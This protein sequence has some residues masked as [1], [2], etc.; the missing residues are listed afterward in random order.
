MNIF[1]TS[2]QSV[3]ALIGIGLLGFWIIRKGIFPG[4]VLGLLSPLA[5]DIALPSLIFFNI[6]VNFSPVETEGWWQLPL[7]W[8]GFTVVTAFMTAIAV[9]TSQRITRREFALS[10]FYQ[11]ALFFPLIILTGLFG[12]SSP[13]MV[14]LFLFAFFYPAFLF[15]TYHFFFGTRGRGINLRKVLHPVLFATFFAVLIRYLGIQ[16]YVPY[17]VVSTFKILGGMSAPIIMI[18][19][20]GNI[21]LDF[22]RKGPFYTG[23]ILKFILFKNFLF[24][25]VVL[26]LLI[27]TSPPYGIAL[28]ILLQSAAPPITAAPLFAEREGGNYYIVNQFVVASF[29]FSL[30]SASLMLLLFSLFFTP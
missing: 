3:A 23:E 7:W 29:I 19:L 8:M 11:N 15:S 24:P 22:Q 18:I 5:L 1:I 28:I 13:Y 25:L 17:F 14:Y 26:V 27:L 16:D 20:G 21:Y 12:E 10:L 2:F 9:F 6:L 30:V 4:T